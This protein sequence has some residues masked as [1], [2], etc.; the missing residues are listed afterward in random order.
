MPKAFP[1]EV[2]ISAASG[3]LLCSF[4]Q[5]H[6]ISEDLARKPIWTHQLPRVGGEIAAT[7]RARHP[8]LVVSLDE[9]GHVTQENW[10]EYRDRFIARHG[11]AIEVSPMAAAQHEHREPI[12]ELAEMVPPDRIIQISE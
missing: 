10:Q 2:V 7:I 8:E 3:M 9:A 4:D 11:T 5:V 12:S 6:E 1:T